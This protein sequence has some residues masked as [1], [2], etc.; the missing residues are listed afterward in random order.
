MEKVVFI[1]FLLLGIPLVLAIG[2]KLRKDKKLQ[3][4]EF[5]IVIVYVIGLAISGVKVIPPSVEE[6]P[7]PTQQ[8][9][10]DNNSSVNKPVSSQSDVQ[11]DNIDGSVAS[12]EEGVSEEP[13][14]EFDALKLNFNTFF[15][16]YDTTPECGVYYVC[17]DRYDVIGD[18]H[19]QTKDAEAIL[20]DMAKFIVK[21]GY[22]ANIMSITLNV[23]Q[24][25]GQK[26]VVVVEDFSSETLPYVDFALYKN[27]FVT[28]TTLV[29]D[30][31]V[32]MK[33]S[34]PEER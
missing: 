13:L 4:K 32:L 14:S 16:A 9:V 22:R 33:P 2:G 1:F 12:A 28:D 27:G 6:V 21:E 23:S 26:T 24:P 31:D 11:D 25:N 8:S 5:V 18:I 17:A 7:V 15:E 29:M 10:T 3:S 34:S 19:S 20:K 30:T